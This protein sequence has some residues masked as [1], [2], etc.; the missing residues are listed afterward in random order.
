MTASSAWNSVLFDLDGTLADTVDLILTCYRHTMKTHLGEAPPDERWLST[1]GAPL[2]DQ[3]RDFAHSDA[4]HE[5]MLKTYVT[6]QRSM[7]DDM[8]TPF[9]GVV[10]LLDALLER[11]IPLGIVTSKRRE[12]AI[13]TLE[14]C[15]LAD[16]FTVVVTAD[17]VVRGKPDP[18]PVLLALDRLGLAASHGV[19]FVGDS[20]FDMSAG[21]E[22]GVST[23]AVTWGPTTLEE[24]QEE[25]PDFIID[26]PAQLL[27]LEREGQ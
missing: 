4:Q 25:D 3:L 13:R 2:R 19:L 6:F 7:H 16:R 20:R 1:M 23:V 24:L 26:E 11:G 15:G 17:D 10:S 9:P 5:A 8:V 22:A 14:A 12:M 21:R 27:V 18:E